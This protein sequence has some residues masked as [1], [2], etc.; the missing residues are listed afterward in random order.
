MTNYAYSDGPRETARI[1]FVGEAPGETEERRGL[2]FVGMAGSLLDELLQSSGIR[3]AETYLCNVVKERPPKNNIGKF[4][5]ARGNRI[6]ASPE[7]DAYLEMLREEL[8]SMPNL[9]VVV[10]LGNVPLYAL[11]G[12]TGIT[13]Y[14]GS[15][16]DSTLVPGLKVI[17]TIH[18]SA[19]LRNY[20]YRHYIMF[21]L[22]RVKEDS[23]TPDFN[24][25]EYDINLDPTIDEIKDFFARIKEA[26]ICGWDTEVVRLEL[27]C[28]SFSYDGK[29]GLVIPF[30]GDHG[31]QW[32][33]DEELEIMRLVGDLLED[34]KAIKVA[35]NATFDVGFL[36]RKYGIVTGPNEDTMIAQAIVA[37]GFPKGL[38]FLTS[39]HTRQPYYKDEGKMYMKVGGDRQAFLR[40]NAL[41]SLVLLPIMDALHSDL[42]RQGNVETYRYQRS[43]IEPIVYMQEHGI[44][45]DVDTMQ[46]LKHENEK[47]RARLESE[48]RELVGYELNHK[49]PKQ[50]LDY[51]Y[52]QQKYPVYKNRKTG[53]PTTDADALKRLSRGTA[54]RA[55]SPV[56]GKILEIRKLNKILDTYL[57]V[58]I[59]ADDRFRFS[60]NPVGTVQGRLSS[61]KTIFGEGTNG[62]NL[63]PVMKQML[64][65][66]DGW[67]GVEMDLSQAENRIVAYVAPEPRMIKAFEDYDAGTGPDVHRITSSFVFEKPPEEISDEEG[68]SNLGSGEH[69]ERDWGK[70]ANHGLNYDLGYRAFALIYELLEKQARMIVY[71]YHKVYPGVRRW[72]KKIQ[73]RLGQNRTLV[74]LLGRKRLFLDRWGDSLFKEAYSFIPQSTVADMINRWGMLRLY[75]ASD[76]VGRSQLLLQV[77]DSVLYQIPLDKGPQNVV[78]TLLMMKNSLEQPLEIE[79]RVFSIPTDCK[80]TIRNFKDMY[81]LDLNQSE[82][83]ITADLS[84]YLEGQ[85]E[86]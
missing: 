71:K 76:F 10:P 19:A 40:Y 61:S 9:N 16:L 32:S 72:H 51:F 58:K 11:T 5:H 86:D 82:D 62:Q 1:A 39:I 14:R 53:R 45:T 20:E 28:M 31:N 75:G 30:V 67:L 55:G 79:G 21:D 80:V 63:P 52:D 7:F 73:A 74:N 22:K 44:R 64:M 34:R 48:L 70:R 35:Q 25:P 37:P 27:Y 81:K 4:F 85:H 56:A 3:R 47:E 60:C 15:I 59:S 24:L 46:K 29:H 69:S 42:E 65:P 66:D 38:D 12:H 77:H 36:F 8:S 83:R 49:S 33:E 26:R 54:A 50:L 18:P 41:D 13:K 17:P 68:S 2:P 6:W 57:S 43:L 84:N 78:H 23:A